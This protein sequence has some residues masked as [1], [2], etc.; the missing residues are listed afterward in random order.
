MRYLDLQGKSCN[1]AI[2]S[3]YFYLSLIPEALIV[4]MLPP[5]DFG[6]YLAV[7]TKKRA[8][9]PAMFFSIGDVTGL[10]F[11]LSDVEQRCAPHP[12]GSPKHSVYIGIYRVLEQAPL[13][14]LG[15]LFVV[16]PDGKVLEVERAET[17]PSYT[18]KYY[19]YQEICPVHPR[20]ASTFDPPRF[21][22]YITNPRGRIFV[23]KICFV[24][25]RLSGL[26]DD[27]QG[28]A[29]GDLPYAAIDHLRDCLAQLGSDAEKHTKTVDRI[30]PGTFP[31]RTVGS[32][33]YVAD[34]QK[35][36]FYPFPSLA[37]LQSKYFDW[38]RS[39]SIIG[40]A[41]GAIV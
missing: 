28:G 30:H 36:L 29:V 37:D 20:I 4:S 12:D 39:A 1:D 22:A 40:D 7:G 16:T 38:W 25:L 34:A 26:S 15:S 10:P 3:H 2:M 27:P 11:D 6:T 35:L 13:E 32:G 9:G 33:A 17:L 23:P 18:G 14:T 31:F 24:D 41:F 19:L 21:A 8:R 5:R